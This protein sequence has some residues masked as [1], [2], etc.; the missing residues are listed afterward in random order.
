MCV[1]S[2]VRD[3]V[4]N[5]FYL[6]F[7]MFEWSK[8]FERFTAF[9]FPLYFYLAKRYT[10]AVAVTECDT[11]FDTES[12]RGNR[13]W[14]ISHSLFRGGNVWKFAH[15]F[16][17]AAYVKCKMFSARFCSLHFFNL[18]PLDKKAKHSGTAVNFKAGGNYRFSMEKL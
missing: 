17:T 3:P 15:D 1:K 14:A 16:S 7:S 13:N 12:P 11:R 9:S 6:S 18:G 2:L 4:P 5:A 8:A 10:T